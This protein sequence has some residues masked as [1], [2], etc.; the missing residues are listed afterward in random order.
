[1][2]R[3]TREVNVRSIGDMEH[4]RV[5]LDRKETGSQY[6]SADFLA[7]ARIVTLIDGAHA[8]NHNKVMVIDGLAVITGSFNFRA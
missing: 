1:M 5:I 3:N 2:P 8:I 7:H 4:R 6:S